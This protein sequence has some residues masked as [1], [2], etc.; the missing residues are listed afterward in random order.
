LLIPKGRLDSRSAESRGKVALKEPLG[1]VK[2]KKKVPLEG[3][4]IVTAGS[5]AGFGKRRVRS[6]KG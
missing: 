2:A 1:T 5:I 6:E 4:K 3:G